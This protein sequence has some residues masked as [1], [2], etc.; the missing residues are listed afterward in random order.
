MKK[1]IYILIGHPDNESTDHLLA[2]NYAKGAREA[3]HEIRITQL[4]DL[5]FDPI[6]HKGYKVI[7]ELE[8]DLKKVQEDISWCDHFVIIY[9]IWW[10]GMPALLKGLIERIWM[11][12]FA[13]RFYKEGPFKGLLWSKLLKS[14]TARIFVTMDNVPII[15]R[16]LFGDITNEMHFG[17]LEFAGFRVKVKKFGR[18]KFL[19][20][21][22]KENL[23]RKFSK[24]GRKEM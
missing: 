8:P 1:K 18:M 17:I 16:I 6:L 21:A 24:W 9:P 10:A 20:Q 12:G 19:T 7:Q 11:P 2:E 22:E 23:E 4:A 15:A 3:G 5:K 14:K 13:F